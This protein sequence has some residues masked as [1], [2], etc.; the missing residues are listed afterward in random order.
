M[1]GITSRR[2]DNRTGELGRVEPSI[3]GFGYGWRCNGCRRWFK[4]LDARDD[5]VV[6]YYDRVGIQY[7]R[8]PPSPRPP[9]ICLWCYRADARPYTFATRN[10]HFEHYKRCPFRHKWIGFA[11]RKKRRRTM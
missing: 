1:G 11:S 7:T 8:A 3:I 6:E 9:F 2:C 5:H 10:D 4:T